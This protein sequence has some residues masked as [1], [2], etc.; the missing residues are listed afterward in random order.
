MDYPQYDPQSPNTPLSDDELQALD[1]L[2][3][4]LPSD[5][6]LNIEALDGYL[7]GLLIGPSLRA[8]LP[9]ADWL[10]MVWGG[11]GPDGAPFAS[12]RQRKRATVLVLRHLQALACLLKADPEAWQ[13][14]F[15]VAE[16]GE[17]EWVSAQDWCTGFLQAVD[18]APEAWSPWFDDPVTGPLLVPIVLLGGDESEL[19][20][21]DVARLNDL[22]VLDELSRGVADAVLALYL[23]AVPGSPAD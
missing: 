3:L 12:N 16:Q 20:D 9:T 22:A 15:S 21:A 8:G 10:P 17:Q 2:L 13:P 18:L 6:A 23:S 19:S 5:A 1:D 4:A 7:T 14:I 11:D